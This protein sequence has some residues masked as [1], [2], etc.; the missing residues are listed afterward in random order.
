MIP[1]YE[2]VEILPK[3]KQQFARATITT[4]FLN[5]MVNED[6]SLF[7]LDESVLCRRIY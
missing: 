2:D 7:S 3:R 4:M 5:F 1:I 6:K